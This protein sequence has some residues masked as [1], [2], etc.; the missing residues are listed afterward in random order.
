MPVK[1]LIRHGEPISVIKNVVEEEKIDLLL[2][3]ATKR[4]GSSTSVR[5]HQQRIIRRLPAPSPGEGE[6]GHLSR[7]HL[8][9]AVPFS[10][11][12]KG[13]DHRQ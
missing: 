10:I 3:P 11:Y 5:A 4:A 8:P 7:G 2:M 13:Q 6:N 1:E 9:T 12:L